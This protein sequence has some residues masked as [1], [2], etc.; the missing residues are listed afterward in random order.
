MYQDIYTQK[1]T[2][3]LHLQSLERSY[4]H[5]HVEIKE[6]THLAEILGAGTH[7]V[8]SMHHQAVRTPGEDIHVDKWSTISMK[9]VHY[10]VPDS[11]VGEKVL[12]KVSPIRFAQS[13]SISS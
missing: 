7:A 13:S 8:N 2:T 12:V 1:E 6:G 3:I 11:L 5:H 4:L 9:N 10:S